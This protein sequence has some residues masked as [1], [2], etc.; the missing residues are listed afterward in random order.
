MAQVLGPRVIGAAVDFAAQDA[1]SPRS[2]MV[3]GTRHACGQP[4]SGRR[5]LTARHVARFD[6]QFGKDLHGSMLFS[7][8]VT[9]DL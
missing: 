3:V 5:P 9:L 2:V 4:N 7:T 8:F 1:N 6:Q